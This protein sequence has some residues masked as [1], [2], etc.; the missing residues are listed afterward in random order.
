MVIGLDERIVPRSNLSGLLLHPRRGTTFAPM[1][2]ALVF[3]ALVSCVWASS[4]R[5]QENAARLD[6]ITP[7]LDPQKK[8]TLQLRMLIWAVESWTTSD[9]ALPYLHRLDSL[10]AELLLHPQKAVRQRA[11]HAR[12]A[13]HFFTGYRAKFARNI[14]VALASLNAAIAEFQAVGHQRAVGECWDALGLVYQVTGSLTRAEEAFSQELA[15]A[16]TLNDDRLGTQALVH[17]ARCAVQREQIERASAYLDPVRATSPE[18]SI[19]V[20]N[21][22][23]DIALLQGDTSTAE[24]FLLKGLITAS[25]SDNPWDSLP[26]LV[27]L[28]RLLYGQGRLEEG[29]QRARQCAGLAGRMDD[30]AAHCACTVLIGEGLWRL[31]RTQEAEDRLLDGFRMATENRYVGVARELGD[32]GSMLY[33]AAKLKELY[34]QL[35]RTAD[36][37]HMTEVWTELKDSVAA[38]SGREELLLA[39]F[40][41]K[42]MRDSIAHVETL[43]SEGILQTYRAN[44]ERKQRWSLIALVCAAL[45]AATAFWLRWRSQRHANAMVLEAQEKLVAAEKQREASEVRTRIARDVHDQLGSDLTKLSL[46]GSE[47]QA[48]LRDDPAS[49]P[50]LV[51][52]IDRVAHEAGR[53]LSDIVWAVD[54]EHDSLTGLSERSEQFAERLLAR[55]GVA[56]RV[57]CVVEGRD[58]SIDPARKRDLY[59]FL[60]EALNNAIKYAQASK[61]E[62]DLTAREDRVRIQVKDDGVGFH[63]PG[64]M[65]TGNGL[66][67]LKERADRLAGELVIASE[68]GGG[69]LIRLEAPL[70]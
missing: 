61:I 17:L 26:T 54:P 10:S 23:A 7:L 6:S 15:I 65:R 11:R 32:E 25:R 64:A 45:G 31:G 68:V 42:E 53:S 66:R 30:D 1:W 33:A 57:H 44:R 43:R 38:M 21:E 67:N 27:P 40:R 46:L 58:R 37:L 18:D 16:R 62:V 34:K 55:S 36:A 14:P 9:R 60:R 8:D 19:A 51:A 69:T 39:G 47:V 49:V 70:V 56:Y 12:G 35:G 29:L 20:T 59:L 3:A 28:V 52:D 4:A 2:K 5:A 48:S 13:F 50:Q 22:R 63:V 41:D 24:T